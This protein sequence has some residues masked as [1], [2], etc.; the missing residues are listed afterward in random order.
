M[1]REDCVGWWRGTWGGV[2]RHG[3]GALGERGAGAQAH[4][5]SR[6]QRLRRRIHAQACRG[7]LSCRLPTRPTAEAAQWQGRSPR[8]AFRLSGAHG[9]TPPSVLP[10][11]THA[12][13]VHS[14]GENGHMFTRVFSASASLTPPRSLARPSV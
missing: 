3:K 12:S 6:Q 4:R 9:N 11:R 1:R 8:G 14:T 7:H 13:H 10:K 5:P 2:T